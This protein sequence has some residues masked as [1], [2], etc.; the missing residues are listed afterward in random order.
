[1]TNAPDTRKTHV[2]RI[3]GTNKKGDVLPH[4]WADV[5]RIDIAKGKTQTAKGWRQGYQDKLL[6]QDDPAADD[7]EPDGNPARKTEIVKVCDPTAGNVNDPEEWIPIPVIKSMKSRLTGGADADATSDNI[8]HVGHYTSVSEN[9][10]RIVEARRIYHYDTNIDDAASAAFD[11]D[12]SL[13]AYV[14]PGDRYT[15]DDSSKDESQYVE[16]EIVTYLKG[17]GNQGDVSARR[18]QVKLLNQY[19][20][21]ESA[22]AKFDVV[23]STGINPPYRLDPR[24]NIINVKFTTL[25][26]V[27]TLSAG[28]QSFSSGPYGPSPGIGSPSISADVVQ[29]KGAKLLDTYAPPDFNNS[30]DGPGQCMVWFNDYSDG[31]VSAVQ[32]YEDGPY[33]G[34]GLTTCVDGVCNTVGIP[35]ED[36]TAP[37]DFG[38]SIVV[39]TQYLMRVPTGEDAVTV[40]IGGLIADTDTG[41]NHPSNN[42][43]TTNGFGLIQISVFSRARGKITK[44]DQLW[45]IHQDGEQRPT[46]DDSVSLGITESTQGRFKVRIELDSNKDHAQ[47]DNWGNQFQPFKVTLDPGPGADQI[48][49]QPPPRLPPPP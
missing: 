25:Y 4:I 26:I 9:Q 31:S 27:V 43:V 48:P 46:P 32:A 2:I 28:N 12:P 19:L 35:V 36:D 39:A 10:A 22:P 11:G 38:K 14:V 24:Q 42:Q 33:H 49:E 6:W 44:L 3:L 45:D 21:D 8:G 40:D 20:I 37:I 41:P 5:E 13:K 29:G 17:S 18:N 23:G 1:M 7:Y 15:R 34:Y 47:T 16:H 30:T